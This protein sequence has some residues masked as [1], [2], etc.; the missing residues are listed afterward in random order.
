MSK[1]HRH[2]WDLLPERAFLPRGGRLGRGMT[3]EGGKGSS[4]PPP[5]PRLVEAQIRSMGIQDDAIQGILQLSREMQPL[6]REQLQ[7][8]LDTA[9][10]AFDQSQQDR[11]WML[12]RRQA[13]GGVQDQ[14]IEDARSFNAEDRA[15]KLAGDASADVRQAFDAQRGMTTRQLGRMG[16]NPSDGRFAGTQNQV[17]IAEAAAQAGAQTRARD[18][19]R[20]EGY[21]LTDRAVNALA[22]YPAMSMQ[23]TGAGAQY[24][25]SGLG[26]ANQGMAGMASGMSAAGSMAGQMGQNASSMYGQQA[27]FHAN[28]QGQDQTGSVLGGL[29]GLAM[30]AA[31]LW[32]ASD[33][34]LKADIE[35]VDVDERTGL[36]IYEFRYVNDREGRRFRGV[37]ADEVKDID[38]GAVSYDDGGFARVDYGR[39]G[40]EFEEVR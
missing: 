27:N 7:F 18:Q 8:G 37:M 11:Q 20:Q 5:D 2:D 22:G 32:A 16:V 29:G 21:A 34:R 40:I 33:R 24:G 19:A 30:G 9:R 6:Q 25:M 4:A 12:G 39:L 36:S 3:L 26:L 23:A 28:M 31:K 14:L 15:Q 10:T 13:L 17:A 38:P 1:F 35:P